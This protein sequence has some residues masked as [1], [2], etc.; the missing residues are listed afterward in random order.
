MASTQMAVS[1]TAPETQRS[2]SLG[3]TKERARLMTAILAQ[4]KK[5]ALDGDFNAWCALRAQRDG[6]KRVFRAW[7]QEARTEQ[8]EAFRQHERPPKQGGHFP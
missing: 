7:R 2:T 1:S 8:Q 6:W 5:A 3:T 4:T